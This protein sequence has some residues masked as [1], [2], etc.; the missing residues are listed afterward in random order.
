MVDV[1]IDSQFIGKWKS[2]K[3]SICV[4]KQRGP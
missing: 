1:K 2:T 3:W 4:R